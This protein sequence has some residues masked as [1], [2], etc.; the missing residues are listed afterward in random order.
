[1]FVW[2]SRVFQGTLYGM[3]TSTKTPASE[4]TGSHHAHRALTGLGVIVAVVLVLI[5]GYWLYGREL[6]VACEGTA[7]GDTE[8]AENSD[9]DDATAQDESRMPP[10]SA[11]S[12][13][14]TTPGVPDVVLEGAVVAEE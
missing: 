9:A 14:P 10:A 5:A 4:Q 3:D 1:M 6:F 12:A 2:C 11:V 8:V 13:L 7:C